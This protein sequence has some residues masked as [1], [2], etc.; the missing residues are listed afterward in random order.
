MP[1]IY[2]HWYNIP[3]N[4][5]SVSTMNRPVIGTVSILALLGGGLYFAWNYKDAAPQNNRASYEDAA[6]RSAIQ[7]WL[8]LA[9]PN[10]ASQ[11]HCSVENL[12]RTKLVYARF[13]IPPVELPG[14]FD[15]QPRFPAA[16]ELVSNPELLRGM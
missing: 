8:D 6:A 14:L 9:L 3:I 7:S 15:R 2:R 1:G 4:A 5:S 11:I 16:A 10:S 13:D 12:E